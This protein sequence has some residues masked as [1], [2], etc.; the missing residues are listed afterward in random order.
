MMDYNSADELRHYG[1]VGMKWGVRRGNTAK[2]YGKASKKLAK[3]DKKVDKMTA[4]YEKKARKA[5]DIGS[6]TFVFTPGKRQRTANR[7]KKASRKLSR[8]LIK[9]DKWVKAMDKTFKNTDVKMSKSQIDAGKRYTETLRNRY[10]SHF[11]Q[12]LYK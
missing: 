10:D 9:A 5:E 7:A 1:V 11:D 6:R 3:L 12:H 8:S 4:K 2:A